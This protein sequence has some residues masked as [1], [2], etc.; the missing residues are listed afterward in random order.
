MC[1]GA[2]ELSQRA[3]QQGASHPGLPRPPPRARPPWTHTRKRTHTHTHTHT[4]TIRCESAGVVS[5]G[6]EE[7]RGGG[8]LHAVCTHHRGFAA[9]PFRSSS[10]RQMTCA[11]LGHS[12]PLHLCCVTRLA[13]P[14]LTGHSMRHSATEKP[15]AIE[16]R[17]RLLMPTLPPPTCHR[18]LALGCVRV[19]ADRVCSHR[20]SRLASRSVKLVDWVARNCRVQGRGQSQRTQRH[21]ALSEMAARTQSSALP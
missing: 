10:V 12:G 13:T 15:L 9:V 18:T 7:E 16:P 14:V 1:E 20:R 17:P 19:G 8:R 21:T 3:H 5:Q 6:H 2:S 11:R 4:H